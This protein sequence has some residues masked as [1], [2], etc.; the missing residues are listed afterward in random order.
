MQT[1][2]WSGSCQKPEERQPKLLFLVY[3]QLAFKQNIHESFSHCRRNG[4]AHFHINNGMFSV[5][6]QWC[7][8]SV[9]VSVGS[10]L[11]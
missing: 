11:L 10:V 2:H 6:T 3:R 9:L 7:L 8:M 1:R 4:N 5:Y